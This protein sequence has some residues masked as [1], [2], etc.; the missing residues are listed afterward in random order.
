MNETEIAEFLDG[1][2][3]ERVTLRV[4]KKL[5]DKLLTCAQQKYGARGKRGLITDAFL[6]FAARGVLDWEDEHREENAHKKTGKH[7]SER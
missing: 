3:S 2:L 7:L 4:S 6:Y 1:D 5:L